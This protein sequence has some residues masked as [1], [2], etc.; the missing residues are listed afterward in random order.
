MCRTVPPEAAASSAAARKPTPRQSR[1]RPHGES[2]TIR[3]DSGA[4]VRQTAIVAREASRTV[5]ISPQSAALRPYVRHKNA[6]IARIGVRIS[7][8]LPRSDNLKA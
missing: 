6:P 3:S 8:K 4:K 5:D 1:V 7:A 2:A